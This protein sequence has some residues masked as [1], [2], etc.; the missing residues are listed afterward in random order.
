ME[1]YQCDKLADDNKPCA[2]LSLHDIDGSDRVYHFCEM[3]FKGALEEFETTGQISDVAPLEEVETSD[4][5]DEV[6][7]KQDSSDEDDDEV[8]AKQDSSNEEEEDSSDEEEE[9]VASAEEEP[10]PTKYEP[11]G[12]EEIIEKVLEPEYSIVFEALGLT[13]STSALL[14]DEEPQ[15]EE[16]TATEQND[17][18]NVL[19]EATPLEQY[20]AQQ[21]QQS[22]IM[23]AEIEKKLGMSGMMS[24]LQCDPLF[25]KACE[26]S[27]TNQLKPSA[28]GSI[29][30]VRRTD[31]P[32][33]II[34]KRIISSALNQVSSNVGTK[35]GG[36]LGDILSSLRPLLG[37]T[38]SQPT[39]QPSTQ[40][41]AQSSAQAP[42]PSLAG[43]FSTGESLRPPPP[44]VKVS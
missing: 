16:Q 27:A 14:I 44:S 12:D 29:L 13:P 39:T 30:D 9:E 21:K 7:V 24:E 34:W 43:L 25:L 4:D 1:A 10:P 18:M 31:I 5:D 26:D 19:R 42:T 28:S 2:S 8:G 33:V 32:S 41:P 36:P 11:T 23:V 6:V 20:K 15:K 22:L 37:L 17:E 3:H 35:L 40:L 38:N